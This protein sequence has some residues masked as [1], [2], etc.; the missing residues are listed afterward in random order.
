MK[1]RITVEITGQVQF[2]MFRDFTRRNALSLNVSGWVKNNNN[3]S[4]SITAEGE[5]ENL[6]KLLQFVSKGSLLARVDHAHVEWG[7]AT[8][9]FTSF[10]ISY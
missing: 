1:K 9:E 2:V 4:V 10:V 6:K 7:A 3:G 8:G 5:E